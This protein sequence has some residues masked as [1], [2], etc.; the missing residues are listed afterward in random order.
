[1]KQVWS[2]LLTLAVAFVV[3]FAVFVVLVPTSGADEL[4]YSLLAF[5][6]P[7]EAGVAIAAGVVVGGLVGTALV[8]RG[9]RR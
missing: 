2:T 6:V 3:G 8:L 9:L 5:R 7:C 4:C 1:M